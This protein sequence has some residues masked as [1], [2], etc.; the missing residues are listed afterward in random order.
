MEPYDL[1]KK[2]IIAW[3]TN[4]ADYD[5]LEQTAKAI[6]ALY[7]ERQRAD[8]PSDFKAAKSKRKTYKKNSKDTMYWRY[9]KR[10]KPTEAYPGMNGDV[11][12]ISKGGQNG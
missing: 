6:Y 9:K 1:E 4:Y 2:D 5:D 10:S 8:K 11:K 12:I 7:K 3:A